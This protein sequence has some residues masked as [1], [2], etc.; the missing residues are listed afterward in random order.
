MTI[1]VGDGVGTR[2]GYGG[3]VR[4]DVPSVERVTTRRFAAT[5]HGLLPFPIGTE[6]IDLSGLD[7]DG[8][9][10]IMGSAVPLWLSGLGIE[11]WGESWVNR[12]GLDMRFRTEL[13][14]GHP[15]TMRVDD[16]G[17]SIDVEFVDDAG[18]SCVTARV[19]EHGLDPE[20]TVVHGEPTIDKAA[21]NRESL[22]GLRL[23]AIDFVFDAN[24]DLD[25][26]RDL[27]DANV[28]IENSW[29]HPAWL[30]SSANAMIR[31]SIDFGSPPTWINA[32]TA[33]DLH[34]VVRHGEHVRVEGSVNEM[35]DRGRHHF[36]VIGL[37][38]TSNERR[39]ASM[40]YSLIYASDART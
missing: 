23:Q 1:A 33:I 9:V 13:F 32:G 4:D 18:V 39:V 12:G 27:V 24:R 35:F 15:L 10:H 20:L 8:G 6:K 31:R 26:V 19:M 2:S 34:D 17:H 29:A 30:A 11:R 25:M 28:W 37:S 40:R 16:N 7:A 5:G 14:E 21:A 22:E 3:T 38:V 36:A